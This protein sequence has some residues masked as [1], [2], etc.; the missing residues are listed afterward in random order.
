MSKRIKWKMKCPVFMVFH[1]LLKMYM[2]RVDR[3]S[4]GRFE[5]GLF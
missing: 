1:H 3:F 4:I 5:F 2:A